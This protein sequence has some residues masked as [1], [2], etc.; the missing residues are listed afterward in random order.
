MLHVA[1]AIV[2]GVAPGI[3][4]PAVTVITPEPERVVVAMVERVFWL[5]PEAYAS[6]D[7]VNGEVV[8][9]PAKEIAGVV[10][11]DE[12]IGHVPV[13]LVTVPAVDVETHDGTPF[14][15]ESTC[16]F[17]P[18]V[19][20]PSLPVPLPYRTVFAVMLAQPVPPWAT[21]NTPAAVATRGIINAADN[22]PANKI[23]IF[24]IMYINDNHWFCFEIG[25]N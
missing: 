2:I 11:P 3:N 13:T 16:P 1:H 7:I 8:E 19:V 12:T 24:L 4:A 18:A 25:V 23:A 6:P 14:L 22:R 9:R 15:R 21:M 17:V 20:V 5:P 10:P